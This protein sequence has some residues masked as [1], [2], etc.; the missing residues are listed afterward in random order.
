M[1]PDNRA[2]DE[3][4]EVSIITDFVR[5][6]AGSCLIATGNTR[7]ICTASVEESLPAWRKGSG[8]G[9]VTAEYAMLPASTGTRKRRDGATKDGRG[10]EI[11]RLIGRSLRQAV[12]MRLLGERTITLDCETMHAYCGS[13]D[14]DSYISSDYFPSLR[15]G[16][17][18]IRVWTNRGAT[19]GA[20][21]LIPRWRRL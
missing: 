2:P 16:T 18:H 12:D 7:V 20:C 19:I 5:T 9:W 6:A 1:R 14:A 4:R 17:N 11:Q 10:V 3:A 21:S 15:T 13:T 8:L